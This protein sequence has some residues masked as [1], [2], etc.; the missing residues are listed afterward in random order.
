ML[1]SC[2]TSS[3]GVYQGWNATLSKVDRERRSEIKN[4]QK[5][6]SQ[7]TDQLTKH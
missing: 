3:A 4:A 6:R 5:E 7:I 2:L 1:F